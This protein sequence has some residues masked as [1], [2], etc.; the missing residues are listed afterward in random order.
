M[1]GQQSLVD[2]FYAAQE[3]GRGCLRVKND[4]RNKIIIIYCLEDGEWVRCATLD[5]RH[6]EKIDRLILAGMKG[7]DYVD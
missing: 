2:E 6:I 4:P 7:I 5:Y 1:K 3:E